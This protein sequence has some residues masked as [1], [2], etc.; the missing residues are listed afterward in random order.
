MPELSQC[1][2]LDLTDTF[3]GDRK[4]LADLFERVL[5]ASVAEAET[6]LDD[7]FLT[8]SERCQNLIRY[9]T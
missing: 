3:A 7:L 9:L 2:R 5:G 8:R 1:L 6:H 4:M